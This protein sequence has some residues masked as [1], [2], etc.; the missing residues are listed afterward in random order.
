MGITESFITQNLPFTSPPFLVWC[1]TPFRAGL[2]QESE[3]KVKAVER[4]WAYFS[5]RQLVYPPIYFLFPFYWYRVG[6][7]WLGQSINGP[8]LKPDLSDGV[9]LPE[10]VL[11]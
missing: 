3:G 6:L 5:Q 1:L 8:T 7:W 11:T 4:G 9:F 10:S 2:Q